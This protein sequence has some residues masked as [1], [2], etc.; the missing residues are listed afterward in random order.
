VPKPSPE[1]VRDAI[2]RGITSHREAT[3]NPAID[4]LAE[5]DGRRLVLRSRSKGSG[6]RVALEAHVAGD[7]RRVIFGDVPTSTQGSDGSHAVLIGDLP[8]TKP[9]D[10]T[11]TRHLLIRIDAGRPLEIDVAGPTA[12]QTT[13]E[14]VIDAINRAAP[15]VASG[16]PDRQLRLQSPSAGAAS[17]I[18][19][20]PRR[21]LELVEF[22]PVEDRLEVSPLGHGD[23]FLVRNGGVADA[24]ARIEL[25]SLHGTVGPALA[26]H[27]S[28][29]RIGLDLAMRAGDRAIIEERPAGPHVTL[30]SETGDLRVL[31]EDEVRVEDLIPEPLAGPLALARGVTDWT[32]TECVGPR[33]DTA[34]FDGEPYPGTPCQTVGMFDIGRLDG[35][36][37]C[38]E[39]VYAFQP[40]PPA[41]ARVSLTWLRHEGGGFE[42][43]LP[44]EL[45]PLFGGRFNEARFGLGV[46]EKAVEYL[47]IGQAPVSTTAL[48]A[49]R[50]VHDG[51][52]FSPIGDDHHFVQVLGGSRLLEVD[53]TKANVPLGFVVAEAPFRKPRFL[54]MGDLDQRARLFVREPSSDT[55][56][57]LIAADVLDPGTALPGD[58]GQRGT[59][60]S[61]SLRPSGPGRYLLEVG[62]PG[63]RFEC[64]R[65]LVLGPAEGAETTA[66]AGILQAKA[67][68]VRARASRTGT[69]P[70][71]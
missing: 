1:Q 13:L 33:F 45:P 5:L 61:V 60:I 10:L 55:L 7:A 38:D 50:D 3:R 57:E 59:Q 46:E 65:A 28:G 36:T 4:G 52:V 23:R 63:D 58:P 26:N 54:A 53:T 42:I 8:L 48:V 27:R 12:S 22:P 62:F 69:H 14:D 44:A 25:S 15:G 21:Y 68:G 47:E 18:E 6:S 39:S 51:V 29:R 41:S 35:T 11:A 19:V 9:V 49:K 66:A 31:A 32:F 56:I 17:T 30:I 64:G 67:A 20:L 71:D 43:R 70:P 2:N 24:T 34:R 40:M 16:T 37:A